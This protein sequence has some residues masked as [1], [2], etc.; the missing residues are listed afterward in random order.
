MTGQDRQL[1]FLIP[2]KRNTFQG[3]NIYCFYILR[4]YYYKKMLLSFSF[5]SFA[6]MMI[7]YHAL[8]VKLFLSCY[9]KFNIF[10]KEG[11]VGGTRATQGHERGATEGGTLATFQ[12]TLK[13]QGI[14]KK[15]RG[16]RRFAT[17]QGSG[18]KWRTRKEEPIQIH[19]NPRR[20]HF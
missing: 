13:T 11:R 18:R 3:L 10:C 6:S 19:P 12:K 17:G 14:L 15:S 4:L 5:F 9:M 8:F 16:A 2:K 7:I 1:M 20:L